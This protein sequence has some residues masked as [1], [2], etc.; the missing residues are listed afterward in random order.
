MATL[1]LIQCAVQQ[2]AWLDDDIMSFLLV[3]VEESCRCNK[4]RSFTK[5]P[6]WEKSVPAVHTHV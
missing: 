2:H 6:V 4:C 1:L 3:P 5:E